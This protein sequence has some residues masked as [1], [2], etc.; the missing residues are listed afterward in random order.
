MPQGRGASAQARP[1][2]AGA[3]QDS[4]TT[5]GSL[6]KSSAN[7]GESLPF[8]WFKRILADDR[9]PEES[10]GGE[11]VRERE[12]TERSDDDFQSA[13]SSF[14][15]DRQRHSESSA[16]SL[17]R[18]RASFDADDSSGDES[19]ASPE[20]ADAKPSFPD[21]LFQ[22]LF[23]TKGKQREKDK[24]KAAASNGDETVQRGQHAERKAREQSASSTPKGGAARAR[25]EHGAALQDV[26]SEG[27]PPDATRSLRA[28]APREAAFQPDAAARERG[29]DGSVSPSAQDAGDAEGHGRHGV[30]H[31]GEPVLLSQ[32]ALRD[33][34]MAMVPSLGHIV[35]VRRDREGCGASRHTF[36]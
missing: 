9:P 8:R 22:S 16:F 23:R 4:S 20:G 31:S 13:Q 27:V 33:I 15:G 26:A 10:E 1:D 25:R 5:T 32:R 29:G 6:R 28:G 35:R 17:F 24:T 30:A 34:C 19:G 14:Y 36:Q 18:R 2:K 21:Q 11:R 7:I 3:R 12:R